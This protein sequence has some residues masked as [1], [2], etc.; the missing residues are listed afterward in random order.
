MRGQTSYYIKQS[1][2]KLIELLW[3]DI[4]Y[5]SSLESLNCLY[6]GFFL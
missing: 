3:L 6:I 5:K 1:I 4:N 2:P